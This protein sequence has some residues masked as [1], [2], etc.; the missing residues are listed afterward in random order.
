MGCCVGCCVR[1]S[2]GIMQV[3]RQPPIHRHCHAGAEK[4]K[5]AYRDRA[6]MDVRPT[7]AAIS[8]SA[9]QRRDVLQVCAVRHCICW[10]H[11]KALTARTQQGLNDGLTQTSEGCHLMRAHFHVVG[12]K[13]GPAAESQVVVYMDSWDPRR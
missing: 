8:F 2:S 5:K 6:T 13:R 4:L 7:I 3:C 9:E 11:A 12:H 10:P 1:L